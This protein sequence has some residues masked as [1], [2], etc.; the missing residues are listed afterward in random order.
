M[1]NDSEEIEKIKTDFIFCYNDYRKIKV[2]KED[3]T[4]FYRFVWD[5]MD[6]GKIN[7]FVRTISSLFEVFQK[8]ASIKITFDLLNSLLNK[9]KQVLKMVNVVNDFN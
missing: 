8:N 3:L 1:I 4:F 7:Y 2:C 5:N 9:R 6:H